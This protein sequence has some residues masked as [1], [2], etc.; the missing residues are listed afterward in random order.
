MAGMKYYFKNFCM[1]CNTYIITYLPNFSV[2]IYDRIFSCS[3]YSLFLSFLFDLF[4]AFDQSSNKLDFILFPKG[5][6]SLMRAQHD[7]SYHLIYKSSRASGTMT[8]SYLYFVSPCSLQPNAIRTIQK[9]IVCL[10]SEHWCQQN[11][12]Y[13]NKYMIVSVFSDFYSMSRKQ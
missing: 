11:Q 8:G 10:S 7:L 4:K 13:G 1:C 12:G 2:L 6:S 5:L 3:P 9:S